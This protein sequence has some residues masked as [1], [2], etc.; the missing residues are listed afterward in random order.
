MK[1]F[2]WNVLAIFSSYLAIIVLNNPDVA[3]CV[4]SAT[5]RVLAVSLDAVAVTPLLTKNYSQ[6]N[7]KIIPPEM[8][9]SFQGEF[10]NVIYD[11][12]YITD[13]LD[14]QR[15]PRIIDAAE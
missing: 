6:I 1:S 9:D 13:R 7:H 10:L 11:Y 3:P 8:R 15:Q 5:V 12:V 14:K 4:M 2:R